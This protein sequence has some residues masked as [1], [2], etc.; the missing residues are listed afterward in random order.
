MRGT[1]ERRSGRIT[2][3]PTFPLTVRCLGIILLVRLLAW[4]QPLTLSLTHSFFLSPYLLRF[5]CPQDIL[6]RS[7]HLAP[8]AYAP[9]L[10]P[11]ASPQATTSAP[12]TPSPTPSPSTTPQPPPKVEV[13]GNALR[14]KV[15][16]RTTPIPWHP[17]CPCTHP[18]HQNNDEEASWCT[19]CRT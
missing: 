18:L 16:P 13:I 2:R 6:R 3:S 14:E 5:P 10:P 17:P 11:P 8:H 12:A 9:W 19:H 7:P 15:A 4:L 1:Q